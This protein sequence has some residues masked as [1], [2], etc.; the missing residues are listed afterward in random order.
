MAAVLLSLSLSLVDIDII[1]DAL[2]T[3]ADE[4]AKREKYKVYDKVL[5]ILYTTG[6]MIFTHYS[7]T[8][9]RNYIHFFCTG[10]GNTDFALFFIL[11]RSL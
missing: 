6:I 2:H 11:S 4:R 3:N 5:R 7:I 8:P 9:E 1:R 10:L